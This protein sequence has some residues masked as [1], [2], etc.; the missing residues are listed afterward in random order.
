MT[1]DLGLEA[2]SKVTEHTNTC[3]ICEK[4]RYF[5]TR[6]GLLKSNRSNKACISCSNSINNGGKGAL[7]D[8]EGR[9]KCFECGD[10]KEL[11]EYY[12]VG[13]LCKPCSHQRGQVYNKDVY[14]FSRHGMTK[15]EF[16]KMLE[17]QEFKC[18]ICS[19]EVDVGA[20]IDHC[21]KSGKV[22][23][24]LCG[25][26]NKGLGQFGDDIELMKNAIKY[27]EIYG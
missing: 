7:F 25:K 8:K 10:Y 24:I 4:R 21:H 14:R 11:S 12:G 27:L 9:R 5:K 19:I 16:N 18:L 3:P 17:S 6:D 20:H 13:G 26:C 22:R 23:G 1:M 2:L 15:E